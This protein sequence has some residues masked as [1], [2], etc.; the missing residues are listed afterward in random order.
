MTT[1]TNLPSVSVTQ[2]T[3][4][5]NEN[6]LVNVLD[7]RRLPAFEKNP[8]L[9]SGAHRVLPD[10]VD[11]W[12]EGKDKANRVVAYCVYG[13]EVSQKAAQNLLSYGFNAF[14]LDGGISGWQAQGGVTVAIQDQPKHVARPGNNESD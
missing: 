13:H 3:S 8:V 1:P 5:L 14:F 2:L 10:E 4:W 7:V 12:I 6:T 9:I 11:Q